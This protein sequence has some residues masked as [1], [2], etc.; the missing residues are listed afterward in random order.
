MYRKM[1]FGM[2]RAEVCGR[3]RPDAREVNVDRMA[4]EDEGAV[5]LR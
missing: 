2:W 4:T 1:D 3:L 5:E